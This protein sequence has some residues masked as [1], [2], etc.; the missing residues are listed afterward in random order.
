MNH[1]SYTLFSLLIISCTFTTCASTS[2]DIAPMDFEKNVFF[3]RKPEYVL[4]KELPKSIGT[5]HLIPNFSKVI[6]AFKERKNINDFFINHSINLKDFDPESNYVDWF[7]ATDSMQYY[8]A[9]DLES[10]F[11]KLTVSNRLTHELVSATLYLI[12]CDFSPKFF[13]DVKDSSR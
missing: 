4:V 1:I 6:T 10:I 11:V 5:N 7:I 12:E 13:I 9:K 8:D 2:Q 3:M